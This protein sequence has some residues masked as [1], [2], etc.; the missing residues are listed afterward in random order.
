[1]KYADARRKRAPDYHPGD[2]VLLKTQFF[3]LAEGLSCKLA[4][5]WVGPFTVKEVLRPHKLA[6][7]LDLPERAKHMH[8]VVHVPAM[9]P[10]RSSDHAPPPLPD[11]A[12]ERI[13]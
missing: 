6:V 13:P 2:Q 1:M 12:L 11:C 3:Q 4:P 8:S 10:Y 5:R 7:R 9:R